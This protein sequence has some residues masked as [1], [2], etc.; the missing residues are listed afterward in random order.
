[1]VPVQFKIDI[2]NKLIN[3]ELFTLDL[4]M[5][6][7]KKISVGKSRNSLA[8]KATLGLIKTKKIKILKA[9]NKNTDVELT[10]RGKS[11]NY[12]IATND[13]VLIK[14][15]KAYGIKI[16]RLKQKRYLIKE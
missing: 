5:K 1:M 14:T 16:I 8:A 6:E 4:C 9:K 15:L 11:G 3:H 10:E 12:I 7:L 2:F 13:R